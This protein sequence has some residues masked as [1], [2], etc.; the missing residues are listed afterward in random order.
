[1]VN[2]PPFTQMRAQFDSLIDA[3]WGT[4]CKVTRFSGSKNSAG[5]ISGTFTT[6]VSSERLWIQALSGRSNVGVMALNAETT[7]LAFQKRSGT[8]LLPKDR[9]L[10]SGDTYVYD[11]MNSQIFESHRMSELKQDLRT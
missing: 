9:I 10:L 7:H 3:G 5:H 8:P 6:L 2:A 4:P 1:M 11:V